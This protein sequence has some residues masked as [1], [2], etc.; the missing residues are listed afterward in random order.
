MRTRPPI[1]EW[2]CVGVA[3]FLLPRA[4]AEAAPAASVPLIKIESDGFGGAGEADIT[5]VVKSAVGE[6]WRW[7]PDDK[8][9]PIVIRRGR[10]G[11]ITLFQRS[12]RGEIVVKLDVDGTYW[13]QFS[14]QVAHEFCHVLCRYRA[15][16]NP[17]KWF[18]ETL[19]ETASLYVLRAMAHDWVK[20]PPY[21]NWA[22]FHDALRDYADEVMSRRDLVLEIDRLGLPAFYAAHR[23]QLETHPNSREI[24]GAIAVVLLQL[25][26]RDPAQWESVRW[27]NA[28][29]ASKGESFEAYL[30]RWHDAAPASRQA[31]VQEVGRLF[32][33]ELDHK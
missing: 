28:T 24:N 8:L 16:V 32:G 1:A 22:G 12:D 5:A 20:S 21:P 14:Y 33:F 10:S 30:R 31:F 2:F 25:L 13:A 4:G 15:G 17:N 6:L 3:L 29:P 11:P 9:E 19:C 27:L 18:E 7:F 23:A 26:E